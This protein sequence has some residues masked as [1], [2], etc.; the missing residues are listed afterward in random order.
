M[1]SGGS[2]QSSGAGEEEGR[3][4]VSVMSS[5]LSIASVDSR[6]L[7]SV[8]RNIS[9]AVSLL[10]VKCEGCIDSEDSQVIG[11]PSHTQ[12]STRPLIGQHKLY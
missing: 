9:K 11:Q 7:T 12:A 1:F 2:L 5:E 4:V 10:L 8:T 6:L 3:T